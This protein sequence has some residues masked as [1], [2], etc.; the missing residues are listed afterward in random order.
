MQK[1]EK[2][3]GNISSRDREAER[4]GHSA[5]SH[6]VLQVIKGAVL[7]KNTREAPGKG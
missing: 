1:R 5:T 4:R 2:W 7:L 6:L 3:A